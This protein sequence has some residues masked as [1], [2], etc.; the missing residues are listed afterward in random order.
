[1]SRWFG[2]RDPNWDALRAATLGSSPGA[3]ASGI[4]SGVAQNKIVLYRAIGGPLAIYEPTMAGLVAALEGASDGDTVWLPSIQIGPITTGV[5][6][7]PGIAVVGL[8]EMSMLVFTQFSGTAVT[9]N[10]NSVVRGFLVSFQSNGTTAI[11]IDARFPGAAV[12]NMI[13]VVDGG[14]VTNVAVWAGAPDV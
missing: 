10:D 9:M 12:D 4:V 14:S 7:P 13:V 8:S 5:A 3:L 11:G 6:L 1:M 2:K